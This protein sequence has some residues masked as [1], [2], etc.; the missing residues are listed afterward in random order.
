MRYIYCCIEDYDMAIDDFIL[1]NE[2]FPIIE[3]DTEH[4]CAYCPTEAAY[5]LRLPE[6]VENKEESM[7]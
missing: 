6:L 4:T 2:T 5:R 3:E 7:V 1:E